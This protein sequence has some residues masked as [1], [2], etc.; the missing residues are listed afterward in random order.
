MPFVLLLHTPVKN[1]AS[2]PCRCWTA[3]VR[4]L[5]CYIFF[6]LNKPC[7]LNLSLQDQCSKLTILMAFHWTHLSLQTSG[8][9]VADIVWVKENYHFPQPSGYCPVDKVQSAAIPPCFVMIKDEDV[10]H[11]WLLIQFCLVCWPCQHR[12]QVTPNSWTG[13]AEDFLP[14]FAAYLHLIWM[15]DQLSCQDSSFLTS[16][17]II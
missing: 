17:T 2:P 3:H 5:Q 1:L 15:E 10:V 14:N 9:I 4:S 6:M 12:C 8:H 13:K 16:C 11:S 7:Y